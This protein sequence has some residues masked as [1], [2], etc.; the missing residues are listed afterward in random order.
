LFRKIVN[1]FGARALSAVINLLIAIILSQYLG[2]GG[3]GIQS[4][5]ITTITFILVFANLVGGATLV[6]LVPRHTSS[7][8]MLP[9][10]LWTILIAL[11]S[12]FLLNIFPVVD[13]AFIIH[14]CVLSVLNSFASINTSMLIGKEKINESNV[15]AIT[16]PVI[17]IISLFIFFACNNDPQIRHYIYSLYISFTASVIVSFYYYYKHFGRIKIHGFKAYRPIV[18]E[19]VRYGVL[20]QVAHITQMLSFRLSYYVLD[21]YHGES[22]VGVYSNGISLAESIWL[23]SKSI[24]MVQ[25]ARISNITERT[26][27]ARLTTRLIKFSLAAS[28]VL[29]IPLMLLPASFYTFIFGEGF[30]ETRMVVWA[31]SFGV[32]VYNFS[33]LT[34]HYFS[35][36]GRYHVNAISSSIG[37]VASVILYFT[38]IPKFGV[39]GAGWATSLSYL[40]TTIIL[41]ILFNRENKSWYKD[42][43]PSRG[44]LKQLKAEIRAMMPNGKKL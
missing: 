34:G 11:L 28:L 1:T 24:S 19:M 7:L 38:F 3:K 6:Y 21:Y 30:E 10:Y 4:L 41:M 5:I 39:A 37:L 26:E 32:L 43:I 9:S 27:A 40:V 29:L 18:F 15:I 12:Y 44:D 8:L 17:L 22:A 33:I 35:G 36:T 42:L 25:Y 2:P 14:I 20:N 23:I 31:L 13:P 16:Q